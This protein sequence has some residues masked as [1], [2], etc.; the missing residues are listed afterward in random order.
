MAVTLPRLLLGVVAVTLPGL[1]SGSG[2]GGDQKKQTTM[3]H[4]K[5]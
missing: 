5:R 2:G 1:L 4:L 3:T